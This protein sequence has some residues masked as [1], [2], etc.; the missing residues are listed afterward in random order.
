MA[1]GIQKGRKSATIGSHIFESN[2]KYLAPMCTT[3]HTCKILTILGGRAEHVR[4]IHIALRSHR[5]HDVYPT[6]RAIRA[7]H[8]GYIPGVFVQETRQTGN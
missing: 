1:C 8:C 5:G 4:D 2:L 6:S 7:S 3:L